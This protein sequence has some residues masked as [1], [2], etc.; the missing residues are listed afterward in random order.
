MSKR[1]SEKKEEPCALICEKESRISLEQ[2]V[3]WCEEVVEY[4]LGS[5]KS[6]ER[7]SR[8]YRANG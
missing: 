1:E 6:M 3:D 7:S 8:G 5:C 2:Y 4:R